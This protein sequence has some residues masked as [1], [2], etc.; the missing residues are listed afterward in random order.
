ML[1][2]TAEGAA[3]QQIAFSLEATL[4]QKKAELSTMSTMMSN[5]APEVINIKRE[6]AAVLFIA[7]YFRKCASRGISKTTTLG[8]SRIAYPSR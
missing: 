4:A 1:D 5:V 3:F 6:I 7:D 2:P 8:N